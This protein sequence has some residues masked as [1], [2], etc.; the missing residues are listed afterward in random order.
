MRLVR[1]VEEEDK[2]H[3]MLKKNSNEKRKS[4]AATERLNRRNLASKRK[5]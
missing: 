2:I 4:F 5:I 1:E 3:P